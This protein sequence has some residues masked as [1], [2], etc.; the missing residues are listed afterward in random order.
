MGGKM[1]IGLESR[2]GHC[3]SSGLVLFPGC[4]PWHPDLLS[5]LLFVPNK[6]SGLTLPSSCSRP[7]LGSPA[8]LGEGPSPSAE[9]SRLC[10]I[11]SPSHSIL[12]LPVTEANHDEPHWFFVPFCSSPSLDP[13]LQYTYPVL[14]QSSLFALTGLI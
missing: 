6:V 11:Q 8:P 9:H 10:A 13:F 5:H 12:S 2:R 14:L 7:L 4:S 3:P 1:D